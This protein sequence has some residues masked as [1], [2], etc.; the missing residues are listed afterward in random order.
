MLHGDEMLGLGSTPLLN[1][2]C[3]FAHMSCDCVVPKIVPQQ[4]ACW[5]GKRSCR[6]ISNDG[7][8]G[9]EMSGGK[10]VRVCRLKLVLGSW[11]DCKG[12]FKRDYF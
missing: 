8:S 12:F 10:H 5:V 9:R 2:C 3:V 1:L 7:W 4:L 11:Q 6:H